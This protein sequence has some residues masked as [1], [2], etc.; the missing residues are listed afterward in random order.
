[1]K[2]LLPAGIYNVISNLTSLYAQTTGIPINLDP[3]L[4][5]AA[6]GSVSAEYRMSLAGP[7]LER[8]AEGYCRR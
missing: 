6:Y 2:F 4:G 1:M 7:T 5:L 8:L 3:P